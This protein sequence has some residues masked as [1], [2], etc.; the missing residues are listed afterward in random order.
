MLSDKK[1]E[2]VNS[3]DWNK[4]KSIT[5]SQIMIA[6]FAVILLSADLGGFR[7]IPWFGALRGLSRTS[8]ICIFLAF[9]AS[10]IFAWLSLYKMRCLLRNIRDAQVF[11]EENTRILRTVSHACAAVSVICLLSTAGYV[12]F[13]FVS[14][15]AAFMSLIVRIVKNVFQQAISMKDELDLTI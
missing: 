15:A 14:A 3:M 1:Q 6:V 5:L 11:T 8:K 2:G 10:S 13:I 7:I 4:D 12:P 9:Y